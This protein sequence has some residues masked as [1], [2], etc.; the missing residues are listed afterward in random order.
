M[1]QINTMSHLGT[2]N[3]AA[4]LRLV[5]GSI[6]AAAGLPLLTACGPDKPD[7][8][9][10]AGNASPPAKPTG[11]ATLA[12]IGTVASLDPARKGD[13]QS[14]YVTE[15]AYDG[16]TNWKQDPVEL[17]PGLATSWSSNADATIWTFELRT[18]VTFHDGTPLTA[19]AVK[20]SFEHYRSGKGSF[21]GAYVGD[22]ASIDDSRPSTVVIT[23]PRPFPD[24]ARNAPWLGIVSAQALTGTPDE[25]AARLD[26]TSAGAGAFQVTRSND[27]GT[28]TATAFDKYWGTG[29]YLAK[30]VFRSLPD[31]SARVAAL[32]SGDV[33]WIPQVSPQPFKQLRSAYQSSTTASWLQ[34]MAIFAADRGPT[35]NRL[36][37]QAIAYAIDRAAIVKALMQD[38]A[39]VAQSNIPPGCYGYVEAT[40]RY[41]PD[42]AKV[43]S[44]LSGLGTLPTIVVGYD[45]GSDYRQKLGQ[46]IASQLSAAGIPATAQ[47]MSG[48]DSQNEFD[49]TKPRKYHLFLTQFGW[50]N[51]GPFF[52]APGGAYNLAALA[53]YTDPA[54]LDLQTR[55]S[56]VAD[57]PQRLDL[58]QQLQNSA[59]EEMFALALFNIQ[60]TDVFS[61]ELSGYLTPADGFGPR[62]NATY[63]NR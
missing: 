59:A 11:T 27:G 16:L 41:Q 42:P 14:Y 28:V 63:R 50:I 12:V 8:T 44:L 6:A 45:A 31:E 7:G 60:A 32:R 52:Y 55:A 47:V 43:K 15:A 9:A 40:P 57:G 3:R 36:V 37:R 54:F 56:S 25:I 46:V 49:A 10:P 30:L 38:E 61:R 48:A 62:F 29:P 58:M 24:L 22:F 17:A 23:Y 5:G 19:T 21:M 4:F 39:Q 26:R 34:T 1:S 53:R 33:D 51:G 20:K 35:D 13:Y 18:D 2:L